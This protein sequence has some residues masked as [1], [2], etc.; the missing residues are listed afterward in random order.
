MTRRITPAGDAL[1]PVTEMA[2]V[3][4]R[5]SVLPAPVG[6]PSGVKLALQREIIISLEEEESDE[7]ES[8]ES[9]S[10]SEDDLSESLLLLLFE[11]LSVSDSFFL[12]FA[13]LLSALSCT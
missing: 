13:I 11:S 12:A 3:F 7:S 4:E 8:L 10:E 5:T 1:A 9:E 2:E 6:K